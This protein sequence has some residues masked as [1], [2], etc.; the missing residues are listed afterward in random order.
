MAKESINKKISRIRPPRVHITYDVETNGAIEKKEIPFVVG[1]LADLS[2]QPEKPLPPIKERNFVEIDRD[3]FDQV[4]AKMA[5]RLGFKVDNK[6]SND[7]TKLGIELKFRQL[8]DFEPQNVVEQVEPLRKLLELRRKLANL[9]SSLYGNDRLDV[10]LQRVV[11][12]TEELN[13]LRREV[14]LPE[15]GDQDGGSGR[16]S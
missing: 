10:L 4:M 7:D 3:N 12:N 15:P 16:E 8:D 2:G 13:Q 1:V 6:L 14:G 11:H 9:R 5:P